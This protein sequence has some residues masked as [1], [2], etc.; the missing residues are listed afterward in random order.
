M[1]QTRS[2]PPPSA[3]RANF[4][5]VWRSCRTAT[6]PIRAPSGPWSDLVNAYVQSGQTSQA[7][8]FI[9]SVLA[10]N[11]SNAEALV[12]MGSVQLAKNA[13]DKAEQF[14]RSAI[15]KKPTDPAGYLALGR[16]LWPATQDGR[17][18]AHRRARPEAAAGQFRTAACRLPR[19]SKPS[20]TMMARSR[21]TRPC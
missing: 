7:E 21:N 4:P 3:A 16:T 14:F 18:A 15:E 6:A 12:L 19:S 20:G 11:P 8:A 2:T 1:W 9:R 5:T 17:C 10:D 13:P